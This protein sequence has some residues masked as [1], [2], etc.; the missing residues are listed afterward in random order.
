MDIQN[1]NELLEVQEK[2]LSD[3]QYMQLHVEYVSA[4]KRLRQLLQD[5]PQEKSAV[6]EQY[7]LASAMLH[8]RLM[9]LAIE[10]GKD[11][12]GDS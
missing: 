2:A 12:E 4:E 9:I 8:H 6:L 11:Y 3:Q 10:Y 7:I 5:L 1:I